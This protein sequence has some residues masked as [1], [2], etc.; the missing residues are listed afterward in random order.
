[1]RIWTLIG[2]GA[3]LALTACDNK[4]DA[5]D[6][7]IPGAR[8]DMEC[9]HLATDHYNEVGKAARVEDCAGM[10]EAVRVQGGNDTAKGAY[11]G[12]KVI[13][14]EEGVFVSIRGTAAMPLL[15]RTEDGQL[16]PLGQVPGR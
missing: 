8:G 5:G 6:I 7:P 1:M 13:V 12:A 9:Y 11:Q 15:V 16:V 14:N 10:L 2:V 4:K 3:V